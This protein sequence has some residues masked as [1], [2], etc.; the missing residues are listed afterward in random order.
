MRKKRS[1]PKAVSGSTPFWITGV[2]RVHRKAIMSPQHQREGVLL[3]S[4]ITQAARTSPRSVLA[5]TGRKRD[6]GFTVSLHPAVFGWEWYQSD[7]KM[8]KGWGREQVPPLL[9]STVACQ[10]RIFYRLF[11]QI[12][13]NGS[14]LIFFK[15]KIVMLKN[16]NT[17][18]LKKSYFID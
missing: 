7:E 15:Y 12:G 4:I 3:E 18:Q 8:L 11:T 1:K 17:L 10:V 2:F 6:A 5:Q 14:W 13:T 9:M 16:R